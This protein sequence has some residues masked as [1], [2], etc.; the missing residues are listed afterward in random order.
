MALTGL[1]GRFIRVN[2]A[3][4]GLVDRTPEEL[5]L[6]SVADLT[7]PDD[8]AQ[9]D[10]NLGEARTGAARVHDVRKR[11]LRADGTPFSARVHASVVLDRSGRPA[12][13]F[14]HVLEQETPAGD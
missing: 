6:M 8:L 11:Y 4:A 5:A 13:V 9:D 7:H 3:Y 1:D 10:A 14:A 2:K 12:Y